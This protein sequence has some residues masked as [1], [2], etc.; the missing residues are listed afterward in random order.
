MKTNIGLPD[1]STDKIAAILYQ[2]LADETVLTFLTRD[3]HWNVTGPLFHPL[4]EMFGTQY[5]A[6]D[7]QLDEI[8]ERIRAIGRP[9]NGRLSAIS[10]Q[11]SLKEGKSTSDAS[12][13]IEILLEGHESIIRG[14]RKSVD[15]TAKL[16]DNGTSDFLTGL[17]ESHEKTAWM[18]RSSL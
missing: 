15:E 7:G 9:L 5:D 11:A 12:K 10:K 3:A 16:G 14:L 17:M 8:A 18:L 6:L 13:L 1:K 4:H 2:L